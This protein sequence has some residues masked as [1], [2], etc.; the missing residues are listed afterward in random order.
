MKKFLY[1]IEYF[2]KW[3][4]LSAILGILIG[5]LSALFLK[6]L[7]AVTEFRQT[8]LFIIFL[9][10]IVGIIV[11]FFYKKYGQ[12]SGKGNNL[13]IEQAQG[14]NERVPLRLIP[15][16][17]LGTILAHLFGAS[18]GREG[19]AVQMGGAVADFLCRFLKFDINNRKILVVAGMAAGFSSIFGTPLAGAIFAI[20]VLAIGK[21]E[22]MSLYPVFL[23]SIIANATANLFHIHHSHF[24]V[25]DVPE[26][27]IILIVKLFIAAI[28]FGVVGGLFART[29]A[30]MK[31]FLKETFDNAYLVIFIGSMAIT[32]F[33]F[34][35]TNRYLGLSLELLSDSFSG[36]LR[37]YDFI[38]KFIMTVFSLGIGF[39]GGEVTPLFE[40]GS[41]LG[42]VIASFL[43][44]PVPLLAALG[45]ICVFSSATN[46][47]IACLIMGV[48]LF[49]SGFLIPLFFVIIVSFLCSGQSGI[50]S[51]QHNSRPKIKVYQSFY[52]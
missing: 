42:A 10:P 23:S 32:L 25:A 41:S 4:L 27:S 48:E 15:L 51:S 13:I 44:L 12:N 26:M 38:G 33:G 31:R 35:I 19:T 49:G 29:I 40:I 21:L 14:G 11:T 24:S 37:W 45:Y 43:N 22:T 17:F 16:V 47:P 28:C 7:T 6:S 52:H 39:Q 34:F 46:T 20:E 50:Y 30:T 18:V 36:Q 9:L 5:C 3:T 2:V 8:H 1:Y